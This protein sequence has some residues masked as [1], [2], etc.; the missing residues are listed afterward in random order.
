MVKDIRYINGGIKMNYGLL[1]RIVTGVFA[2][3]FIGIFSGSTSYAS[4]EHEI[5]QSSGTSEEAAEYVGSRRC[6][7][8]HWREH[9]TWKHT[10][11][12]KFMQSSGEFTVLGDFEINNKIIVKVSDQSPEIAG[13]EITTTMFKKDGKYY[14][15]TIGPDWEFHNYQIAY[16]IGINKRQNYLTVFPNGA[17]YVLPVEWDVEKETWMINY[18]LDKN[19]PGNGNYWSDDGRIW[20]FKCGGCH[21]TGMKINYDKATHSFD[22]TF[23]SLGIGCESCHGPGSS[24]VK[25]ARFNYDREKE[26]II[27]PSKLPWRLRAAVCGQCH[28]WGASTAKVSPYREGFPERYSYP[29]GF[30]VGKPLYLFYVNEPIDDK[31]HHQQYNEWNTSAHAEAGIMCTTC[32]AVHQEG[33]HKNPHKALTKFISDSLC[34]NCHKTTRKRAAHRIHT[35]GSCIACHMPRTEWNE[36][37]HT[38]AFVS[39]EESLRAGGVDKKPNSCSGCHHHKNS[40]LEGLIEFLDAVKKADM[41]VPFSVHGR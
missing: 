31:L 40:P 1:S 7:D 18:G 39:P 34:T 26:T 8:C 23:A 13:K 33:L 28:N 3:F 22:T 21:S 25:A 20:Q 14:I 35:F 38:F 10:L 11:H 4:M 6:K 2:V 29:Y 32:H 24:H 5:T 30:E 16:V 36:H 17:I 37:S 41:P 19:Y 12:S 15:N 9:D 27:N